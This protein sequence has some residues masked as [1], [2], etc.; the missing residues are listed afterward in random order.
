MSERLSRMFDRGVSLAPFDEQAMTVFD[1]RPSVNISETDKAYIVKADLPDVKKDDIKISHENGV[2]AI[3]GERRQEKKEEK[4]KMHR[5]ESLYG[6][7]YRSFTLPS[8]AD[9]EHIEAVHRDG[10]LTVTVPKVPGKQSQARS[11]K[12]S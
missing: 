6:R 3:E 11:I 5:V 2:L 10:S 8:D 9:P 7:F 4:E 12:V 1:W